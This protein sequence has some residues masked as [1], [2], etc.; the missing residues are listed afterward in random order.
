[1]RTELKEIDNL[2][3]STSFNKQ[4]IVNTMVNFRL[5]IE[6]DGLQE[7]FKFLNLYLRYSFWKI[8]Q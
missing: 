6:E 7:T 8:S 4:N 5:I 3:K 1:M 2:F